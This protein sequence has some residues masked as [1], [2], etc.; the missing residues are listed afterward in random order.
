MKNRSSYISGIDE[1]ILNIY[2]ILLKSVSEP[3][4]NQRYHSA[5]L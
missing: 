5:S 1:N 2:L 3:Q 4:K